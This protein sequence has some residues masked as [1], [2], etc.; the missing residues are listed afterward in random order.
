MN[1]QYNNGFLLIWRKKMPKARTLSS[2]E[3]QVVLDY[4]ATQ[5]H[6]ARNRCALLMTHWAGMRVGE[7]SALTIAD[8][9]DA[10][11]KVRSQ[12]YLTPDKTKG[13]HARTVFIN[14]RLQTEIAD[15]LKTLNI[16][17]RDH[18]L[19]YT[20]K[21]PKRGFTSNTMANHFKAIYLKAGIDG[22]SSHSGRRSFATTISAHGVSV[23]V[24]MRALGHRQLSSTMEYV[25]AS[26]LMLQ[27][28][29]EL[30]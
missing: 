16:T 18:A 9:L 8:V 13:K 20:Q 12:I 17:N 7:T 26:D 5:K 3:L 29:V 30:A 19:F 15:Y 28:A 4:I 1:L 10:T 27:N 24:L 25:D 2:D 23:R 6:A 14:S 21:C 11:G 22:C